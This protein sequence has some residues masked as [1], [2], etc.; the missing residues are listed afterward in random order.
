MKVSSTAFQQAHL[1]QNC[2]IHAV[3]PEPRLRGGRKG[4][5]TTI[6]NTFCPTNVLAILLKN[7]PDMHMEPF[8]MSLIFSS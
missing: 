2:F 6:N 3:I 4:G 7:Y 1:D 8:N 5:K